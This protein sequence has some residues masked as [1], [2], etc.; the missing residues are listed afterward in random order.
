MTTF[1][2]MVR[3]IYREP[4]LGAPLVFKFD[5]VCNFTYLIMQNKLLNVENF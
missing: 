1:F 4:S 2:L 5:Y 3:K